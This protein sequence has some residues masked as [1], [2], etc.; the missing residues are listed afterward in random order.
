MAS[1][2]RWTWVWASSRFWWWQGSLVCCSPWDHKESDITKQVNWLT[3]LNWLTYTSGVAFLQ[4]VKHTCVHI[5]TH[6]QSDCTS[7]GPQRRRNTRSKQASRV[8]WS[9]GTPGI[10]WRTHKKLNNLTAVLTN[11]TR[12]FN[13]VKLQ[14]SLS[15]PIELACCL[16]KLI[17]LTLKGLQ[18]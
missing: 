9:Q 13:L 7:F 16:F 3:P 14:F 6:S 15:F 5:H 2:A 12:W 18:I 8:G 11:F 1:P 4:K 10:H 17:V